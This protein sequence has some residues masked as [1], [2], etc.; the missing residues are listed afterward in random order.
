MSF[1]PGSP[2]QAGT[3][4]DPALESLGNEGQKVLLVGSHWQQRKDAV[5]K[6]A[7][8]VAVVL[9]L[10]RQSNIMEESLQDLHELFE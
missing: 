9:R 5:V 6:K 2:W 3:A 4:R 1:A 10:H 7:A 8:N